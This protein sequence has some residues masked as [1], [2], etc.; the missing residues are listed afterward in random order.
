MVNF[1]YP[2]WNTGKASLMCPKWPLQFCRPSWHVS[3]T[4]VFLEI[5]CAAR[6]QYA[7]TLFQIELPT[8][9]GSRAPFAIGLRIF[10]T[11]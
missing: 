7:D 4:S 5:P 11:S 8:S 9:F 6:T 10:D 1:K 2:I 3:H